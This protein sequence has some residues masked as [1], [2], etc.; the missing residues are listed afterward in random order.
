MFERHAGGMQTV[1]V[2]KE[3][4]KVLGVGVASTETISLF[5]LWKRQGFYQR[6]CVKHWK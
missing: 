5:I 1:A 4:L 3:I 2:E 6:M